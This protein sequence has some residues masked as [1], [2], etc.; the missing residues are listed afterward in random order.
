MVGIGKACYST[1][2][3]GKICGTSTPSQSYHGLF[4]LC[5]CQKV[6][7]GSYLTIKDTL[8]STDNCFVKKVIHN[9]HGYTY[10]YKCYS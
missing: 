9:V 2:R 1:H 5:H 7:T 6:K 10:I 4:W 8:S 3:L